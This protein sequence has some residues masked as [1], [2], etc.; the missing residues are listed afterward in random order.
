MLID[1][2]AQTIC[3][4]NAAPVV[5]S[6]IFLRHVIAVLLEQQPR[7]RRMYCD[8]DL[9]VVRTLG[10]PK[11]RCAPSPSRNEHTLITK[12]SFKIERCQVNGRHA[13][14]IPKIVSGVDDNDG[15]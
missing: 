13:F 8:H 6:L 15:G 4:L 9:T 10:Y 12:Q 11:P 7:H 14:L 3:T 1:E 5:R 2:G